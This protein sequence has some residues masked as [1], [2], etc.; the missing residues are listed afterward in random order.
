M[1]CHFL[2][3]AFSDHLSKV[4]SYYSHIILLYFFYRSYDDLKLRSFFFCFCFLGFGSLS[5]SQ[6][7][8]KVQERKE[9]CHLFP[10]CIPGQCQAHSRCSII[11]CWKYACISSCVSWWSVSPPVKLVERLI[12]LGTPRPRVDT[13]QGWNAFV[14]WL[15]E[16]K[17]EEVTAAAPAGL[18]GVCNPLSWGG[19]KHCQWAALCGKTYGSVIGLLMRQW[20]LGLRLTTPE[21]LSSI[22]LPWRWDSKKG[23]EGGPTLGLTT[24]KS[25]SFSGQCTQNSLSKKAV[26]VGACLPVS[27]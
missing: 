19:H 13:E 12:H 6:L 17:I 23:G 4:T 10:Y 14:G 8:F 2:R 24:F 7:R 9:E 1:K 16:Q 3:E 22:F 21:A 25:G 11:L 27:N 5:L 20:L 18:P 15:N 26:L